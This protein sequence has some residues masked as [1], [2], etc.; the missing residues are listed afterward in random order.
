[1]NLE[2]VNREVYLLLKEGINVS[3]PVH[4][5]FRRACRC[6]RRSVESDHRVRDS[7]GRALI[8]RVLVPQ[9]AVTRI[10]ANMTTEKWM[11]LVSLVAVLAALPV[12][13]TPENLAKVEADENSET[14]RT[15]ASKRS[16]KP[17][18]DVRDFRYGP[19][20]GND[21]DLYLAPDT[22]KR[23]PLL[24]WIHGGAFLHGTK[25][26]VSSSLV[27]ACLSNGISIASINYRLSQQAPFPAPFHDAARAVQ[28]LRF[29]AGRWNIDA[30]KICLAGSS[31]GGGI[32]LWLACTPDRI[33]RK[34]T[35][36]VEHYSSRPNLIACSQTQSS[37]DPNWIKQYLPPSA[38]E[39]R[40]FVMLFRVPVDQQ[41]EPWARKQFSQCSA[42]EQV[43]PHV[44]PTMLFYYYADTYPTDKLSGSH[45]VHHPLFGKKF[46]EACAPFG[47]E[48]KVV[49]KEDY[50]DASESALKSAYIDRTIDFIRRHWPADKGVVR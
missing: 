43:G 25:A 31:A 8:H 49:G 18:P 24:V 50:P 38:Y 30:T 29:D 14:S 11:R 5:L 42:I 4:G 17:E 33:N 45:A 36:L 7:A 20:F 21:F 3:V 48:V 47:V 13:A 2:A 32:S 19:H 1:M 46:A 37:Y 40:A 26:D 35:D 16:T 9:W 15:V 28:Y 12:A 41:T 44:P 23:T 6:V 27:R 34:S 22:G 10:K 39:Q